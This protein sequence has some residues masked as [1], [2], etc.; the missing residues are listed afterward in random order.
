M[1]RHLLFLIVFVSGLFVYGC[2]TQAKLT[3][4]HHTNPVPANIA[5]ENVV[6]YI[7]HQDDDVFI[8]SRIQHHLKSND[9]VYVVYTCLSYQHGQGYKIK[10]IKESNLAM[11]ALN[12]QP[13]HVI[14]L[15][16][17]DMESHKHISELINTTDSLFSI[18]KPD[19]VYTSAYEGGNID[20]DVAN[21]SISHLIYEHGYGFQA[22]E[23]PEYSGYDTRFK[24]KYRNFPDSP[25]TYVKKL[26]EE[27]YKTVIQHWDFYKSQ[28]FPINI[29]MAIT[30]GKKA[31][32]GY[33]YYR[34]L[35][36]YDYS[37][38]PPS[39]KI[40][41]ERYLKATFNDF[42]METQ[43]LPT[44]QTGRT[45]SQPDISIGDDLGK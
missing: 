11:Q 7:A 13:D 5:A 4:P 17:P 26:S 14:Y 8:S 21:L 38:K 44:T 20:H 2:Q 40:A 10:R 34:R 45:M 16:F 35:P 19:I 22:Y 6:F 37:Q 18:I 39:G 32:F 41:Y 15:G 24:F 31:I 23:F 27:E 25:E 36:R 1:R 43:V 30:S 33:E 9:N 12:V 42:I 29:L 28:K 3:H